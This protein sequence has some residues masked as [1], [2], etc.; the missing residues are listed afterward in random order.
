[1][2]PQPVPSPEDAEDRKKDMEGSKLMVQKREKMARYFIEEDLKK[3][4]RYVKS[5]S[6]LQFDDSY[7]S[8]SG[9]LSYM[10]TVGD[11]SDGAY[12]RVHRLVHIIRLRYE[13]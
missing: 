7:A 12:S 10:K 5:G 1:M 13:I 6:Y 4:L 11:I 3:I 8:L 9:K 2:Q